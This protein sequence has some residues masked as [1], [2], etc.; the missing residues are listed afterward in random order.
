MTNPKELKLEAAFERVEHSLA[1]AKPARLPCFNINTDD[2]E[3]IL[4]AAYRRA[5]AALVPTQGADRLELAAADDGREAL[6]EAAQAVVDAT[7]QGGDGTW[8]IGGDGE[9]LMAD[10]VE[11]LAQPHPDVS[12]LAEALEKIKAQRTRT[13]CTHYTLLV[14]ALIADAALSAFQSRQEGK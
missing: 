10:L 11:A 6:V 1:C 12:V 7:T 9:M 4:A 3:L 14:G 13:D 2:A 8:I 5:S